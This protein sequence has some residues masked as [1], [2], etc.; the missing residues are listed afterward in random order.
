MSTY[1]DFFY[2]IEGTAADLAIAQAAILNFQ[3]ECQGWDG[4][5]DVPVV[6]ED[7]SMR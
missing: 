7:G 5:N 3:V 2:R 1:V 4:M 6:A